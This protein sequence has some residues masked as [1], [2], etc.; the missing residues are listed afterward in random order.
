MDQGRACNP[1]PAALGRGGNGPPS[2]LRAWV[3]GSAERPTYCT[4]KAWPLSGLALLASLGQKQAQPC[5]R[6]GPGWVDGLRSLPLP[7]QDD[8]PKHVNCPGVYAPV[9]G[10]NGKT[11]HNVCFLKAEN[12]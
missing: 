12:R 7:R 9:C 5:Q 10:T 4:C 3:G 2:P 1:Q 11:Y 6:L 8:Y